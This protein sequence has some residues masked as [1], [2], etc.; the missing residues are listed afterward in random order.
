[1]TD[2]EII[3]QGAR[4]LVE[5]EHRHGGGLF[6]PMTQARAVF[7]AVAPLIREQARREWW[8]EQPRSLREATGEAWRLRHERDE[9]YEEVAR[10]R[11][12]LL[13]IAAPQR[14]DGSW[15]RDRHE[16]HR[17]AV[18]ALATRTGA[19]GGL[20]ATEVI[21]ALDASGDMYL[22]NASRW[23]R[24]WVLENGGT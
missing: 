23:V 1:M 4:G 15:N 16:C 7:E 3:Q 19:G 10:L 13:K 9:A 21:E 2:D 22:E 8:E 14:P 18:E 12:A 24:R 6:G 17:I 5:M 11:E 20:S